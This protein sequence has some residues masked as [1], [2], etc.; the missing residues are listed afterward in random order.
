MAGWQGNAL[1]Q[2]PTLDGLAREG[3]V[4]HR[5]YASPNCSPS[6]RALLTGRM[7]AAV[8]G[9]ETLGAEG[10]MDERLVTLADMLKGAGYATH[11]VR[12]SGAHGMAAPGT[13]RGRS[14]A[15]GELAL[16]HDAAPC[17]GGQVA[18]RHGHDVAA[19]HAARLPLLFRHALRGG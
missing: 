1:V 19:A 4:L 5:H 8:P 14:L 13:R 10:Y 2:T 3:A 7:P 16:S 15:R 11:A 9:F 12:R 6:R 18:L 17:A